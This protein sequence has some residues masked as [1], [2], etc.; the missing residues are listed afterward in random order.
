METFEAIKRTG[1]GAA[2]AEEIQKFDD[3]YSNLHR[4]DVIVTDDEHEVLSA[5]A[6]VPFK[7]VHNNKI[8][9][10]V[11]EGYNDLITDSDTIHKIHSVMVTLNLNKF[12]QNGEARRILLS[13]KNHIIVYKTE[14]DNYWGSRVPEFDGENWVGKLLTDIIYQIEYD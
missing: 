6:E 10:T 4:V 2:S 8:Y 9:K 3:T 12:E 7:Y 13:T 11:M 1:K 5:D 14:N